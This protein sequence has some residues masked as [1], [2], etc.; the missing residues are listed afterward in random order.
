MLKSIPD[1]SASVNLTELRISHNLLT[2]INESIL[3][4]KK[5]KTLDI[6]HNLLTDWENVKISIEQIYGIFFQ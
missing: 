4:N 1:L 5:L 3:Q 6:S 2:T